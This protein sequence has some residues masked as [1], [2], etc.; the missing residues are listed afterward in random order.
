MPERHFKMTW[1]GDV[2]L[3]ATPPGWRTDTYPQDILAKLQFIHEESHKGGHDLIVYAGDIFHS[4]SNVPYPLLAEFMDVLRS[5]PSVTVLIVAGNH[6]VPYNDMSRLAQRPL[7]IVGRLPNVIVRGHPD[8]ID[9]GKHVSIG[10]IPY[11][12]EMPYAYCRHPDPSPYT[13]NVLAVHYG[14]TEKPMPYHTLLTDDPGWQ[15][16][17]D[18]ILSGHIHDDL[19]V[20]TDRH[21]NLVFNLGA[22]SRGSLTEHNLQRT[23]RVLGISFPPRD[24]GLVPQFQAVPLPVRPADEVFH[25]EESTERQVGERLAEDF[26]AQLG[27]TTVQAVSL[28]HLKSQIEELA[29]PPKVKTYAVEALEEVW[30]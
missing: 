10:V 17:A 24:S 28:E 29:V 9:F 22:I 21:D 11:R 4:K 12:H 30:E 23:P 3:N 25:I 5:Y 15:P 14:V 20:W 2:H 6:D 18:V 8:V 7:G 27:T 16:E 19:G 1:V 13:W 26:I